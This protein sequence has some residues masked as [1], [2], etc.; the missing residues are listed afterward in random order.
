L[1]IKL[2]D[3]SFWEC[4]KGE[5][6][7]QNGGNDDALDESG[8]QP[9]SSDLKISS[10]GPDAVVVRVP[11]VLIMSPDEKHSFQPT[12]TP[13]A[14]VVKEDMSVDLHESY[15]Y[16]PPVHKKKVRRISCLPPRP[17][18]IAPVEV[19]KKRRHSR[20]VELFFSANSCGLTPGNVFAPMTTAI[21][22]LLQPAKREPS[23]VSLNDVLSLD[24]PLFVVHPITDKNIHKQS[25]CYQFL[26]KYV[27]RFLFK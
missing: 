10:V 26:K 21:K 27:L 9:E 23:L 5:P 22:E 17:M 14:T 4:E 3:F 2:Q 25:S 13:M 7:S 19:P 18:I 12:S 11:N 1:I 24:K 6:N 8:I 16:I 15:I 20:P